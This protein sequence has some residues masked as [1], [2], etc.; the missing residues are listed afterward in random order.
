MV[1]SCVAQDMNK[2]VKFQNR[3]KKGNSTLGCNINLVQYY[4]TNNAFGYFAS[5]SIEYSYFILNR[6][7]INSSLRFNR[8]FYS[9][10]ETDDRPFIS[11]KSL[12]LYFRYYFF[13]RGGVFL[14]LGGSFGHILVDIENEFNRKFYAAPKFDI[15]YSYM[16]T[17]VWKPI[18]NKLSLNLLLSSYIP[19]KKQ[20]NYDVCDYELPFFPFFYIEIGIIYYFAIKQNKTSKIK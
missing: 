8:S 14:S 4:E 15:G 10:N 16:I 20:V 17:N 13:K 18:D 12:D 2:F 19:Y 7:S 1:F 6:F 5:P 11:Q 3:L 9:D